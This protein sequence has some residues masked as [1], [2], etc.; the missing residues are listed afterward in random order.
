MCGVVRDIAQ[1]TA[2]GRLALVLEGGYDLQGLAEGVSACLRVMRGET[3][4]SPRGTTRQGEA[5]VRDSR[6]IASRYWHLG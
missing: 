6:S 5:T 4:P 3:P 1:R 2:E